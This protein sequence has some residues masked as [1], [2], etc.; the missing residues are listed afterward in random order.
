[1]MFS[2]Q[3][4]F[5]VTQIE[6]IQAAFIAAPQ[7]TDEGVRK[8]VVPFVRHAVDKT[9]RVEP[10]Q[11]VTPIEWTPSRHSA[12]Q[13]KAPNVFGFGAPYYSRQKAYFFWKIWTGQRYRRTHQL[14]KGWHVIGDYK[15]GFGGILIYNDAKMS[16]RAGEQIDYKAIYV[17]G[18]RQQKFHRNT[19][20]PEAASE[21]QRISIEAN[22]R[23]ALVAQRVGL[24]IAR[25]E[26][27]I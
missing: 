2:V 18:R 27:V 6:T 16:G 13:N 8:D 23:L 1:M 25:G 14:V 26:Q 11:A 5:D 7:K 21:I 24:A 10:P 4:A 22:E 17:V 9:L 20:W 19:G 3:V 15:G 12:D